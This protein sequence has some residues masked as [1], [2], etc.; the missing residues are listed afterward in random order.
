MGSG[1]DAFAQLRA[2]QVEAPA[3]Y[4][5]EVNF[6]QGQ[7]IVF[8]V[9]GSPGSDEMLHL[10]QMIPD[11]SG[12]YS[13]VRRVSN[14]NYT[15][16]LGSPVLYTS[17]IS[18]H[19]N[20]A[21][22]TGKY[23]LIVRAKGYDNSATASVYIDGTLMA[24]NVPA[25]GA[26]IPYGIFSVAPQGTIAAVARP[27]GSTNP[28][29]LGIS[30]TAGTGIGRFAF[31]GN[32]PG[33]NAFAS[34]HN[35]KSYYFGTPTFYRVDTGTVEVHR[36]GMANV[37]VNDPPDPD[38]DG[39]GNLLEQALGTCWD[40]LNCAPEVADAR[41]T[42]R[43]GLPDGEE[44]FGVLATTATARPWLPARW[45]AD[46]M[47]KDL[48]LIVGWLG[49]TWSIN[50]GGLE[51]EPY[52]PFDSSVPGHIANL[53]EWVT[54]AYDL[55][56]AGPGD[57]V[58][59]PERPC[60]LGSGDPCT[61]GQDW[62]PDGIQLHMDFGS[63]YQDFTWDDSFGIEWAERRFGR[64]DGEEYSNR[65]PRSLRFTFESGDNVLVSLTIEGANHD[66][67]PLV[68]AL[69]D[70]TALA[71][72]DALEIL[73]S[74]HFAP[75]VYVSNTGTDGAGRPWLEFDTSSADWNLVVEFDVLA[76]PN[77]AISV[78]NVSDDQNRDHAL[79]VD[80]FPENFGRRTRYALL[81]GPGAGGQA[82]S[83]RGRYVVG[84]DVV[85]F[86]HELGHTLG[87]GH[88]GH[89]QWY[90]PSVSP[91][92]SDVCGTEFNCFVGY[93]SLMSYS[94][95][96][97][98]PR[99]STPDAPIVVNPSNVAEI[100]TWPGI[101]WAHFDPSDPVSLAS[102]QKYALLHAQAGT[103]ADDPLLGDQVDWDYSGQSSSVPVRASMRSAA[104]SCRTYSE[105]LQQLGPD[106]SRLVGD[107]T[108]TEVNEWLYALYLQDS[109]SGPTV[110]CRTTP[111]GSIADHGCLGDSNALNYDCRVDPLTDLC[112]SCTPPATSP[113]ATGNGCFILADCS[114]GLPNTLGDATGLDS[115][116]YG[117]SLYVAAIEEQPS[118]SLPRLVVY[119]FSQSFPDA[120]LILLSRQVLGEARGRP[121]L[122]LMNGVDVVQA[123]DWATRLGLF[124][125]HA[126]SN[127]LLAYRLD[128]STSTFVRWNSAEQRVLDPT[129]VELSGSL[130]ETNGFSALL[131]WPEEE[132]STLDVPRSRRATCGY[133][134]DSSDAL[135][136]YCFDYT[137]ESW[138]P[139]VATLIDEQ[140]SSCDGSTE[141][142][143]HKQITGENYCLQ[144]VE[145]AFDLAMRH[146][147]ASD[148]SVSATAPSGNLVLS[149]FHPSTG[150]RLML[151]R[152]VSA[153]PTALATLDGG[154]WRMHVSHYFKNTWFH[155]V[156]PLVDLHESVRS[157]GMSAIAGH[158]IDNELDKPYIFPFADGITDTDFGVFSDY[159][160][161]REHLCLFTANWLSGLPA[162]VDCGG[163]NVR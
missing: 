97:S 76:E 89:V 68:V 48:F 161:M 141:N 110:A 127:A 93:E 106:A 22:L 159:R 39:V 112:R 25:G 85:S 109:G 150:S 63:T 88:N 19:A 152:P 34:T 51:S 135:V 158:A 50:G 47:H 40:P 132:T 128:E 113:P 10:V 45:G 49:S 28:V 83:G 2:A 154:G 117:A 29:M 87:I 79:D 121:E 101:D 95:D 32:V 86:V 78:T 104:S 13:L 77:G 6:T 73:F 118:P 66:A 155:P 16:P 53:Q 108:L 102:P 96:V 92:Y 122:V 133:I 20:I 119:R 157:G 18:F 146:H 24:S 139:L 3:F 151:H 107:V 37:Y 75:E 23:M 15:P 33:V 21:S 140:V 38:A 9:V 26:H 57:H 105:G 61:V 55:F 1:L 62:R 46:P 160:V 144:T 149:F 153:G 126:G 162:Q 17:R 80:Y 143:Y 148:G 82:N 69:Q 71:N 142:A 111:L 74:A 56:M 70:G 8:E 99:F 100:S 94:A 137:T 5:H 130:I 31:E 52:S 65:V 123:G 145:G 41:D 156:R 134:A 120:G 36:P 60:L 12:G 84:H 163:V 67:S 14:D 114:S 116:A 54:T 59:N 138:R 35:E 64:F 27:G 4:V 81:T 42:D 124:A 90:E 72:R 7:T 91:P 129:I 30:N 11:G 136:P 103:V 44:L 131:G 58:M 43:D 115:R 125:G 98:P 147:R